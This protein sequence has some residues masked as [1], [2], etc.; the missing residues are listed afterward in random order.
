MILFPI[1]GLVILKNLQCPDARVTKLE[2]KAQKEIECD[3]GKPALWLYLREDLISQLTECYVTDRHDRQPFGPG[4]RIEG[5][6][7]IGSGSERLR[8][9]LTLVSDA[10]SGGMI[11]P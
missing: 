10:R 6:Q 9:C 3:T 2:A 5:D 1:G 8:Q 4:E 7:L 11:R